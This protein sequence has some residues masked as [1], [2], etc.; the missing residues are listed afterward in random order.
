MTTTLI[1][2]NDAEVALDILEGEIVRCY[3][4]KT[5]HLHREDGPALLSPAG[6][7]WYIHGQHITTF[8]RFQEL[9]G[10]SDE[11]LIIL[12]LKWGAMDE[13]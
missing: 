2:N 11:E 10:I 12:K 3:M 6:N 9:T 5:R 7:G 13:D 1:H 8:A 4:D